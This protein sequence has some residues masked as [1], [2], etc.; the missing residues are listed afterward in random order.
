MFERERFDEAA[1]LLESWLKPPLNLANKGTREAF[2]GH[3]GSFQVRRVEMPVDQAS[4][5]TRALLSVPKSG[6]WLEL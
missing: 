5:C 1:R 2:R 4:P 3:R 6:K